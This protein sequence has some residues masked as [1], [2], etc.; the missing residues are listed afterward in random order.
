MSDTTSLVKA[1]YA[2]AVLKVARN[3]EK[4]TAARLI[5]GLAADFPEDGDRLE[6]A[7]AHRIA[8]EIYGSLA[9]SLRGPAGGQSLLWETAIAATDRW[10]RLLV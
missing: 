9:E 5:E 8:T 3:V 6:V 1:K 2:A 10:R 7:R 4:Q